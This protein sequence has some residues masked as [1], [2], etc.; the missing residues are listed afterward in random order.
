MSSVQDKLTVGTALLAITV[1]V[2]FA[3]GYIANIVNIIHG[4]A[5]SAWGGIQ[6]LEVIGVFVAPLGALL[7]YL[8]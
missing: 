8:V 5:L 3:Y 4:P 7:G 1:V 6:V 2:G